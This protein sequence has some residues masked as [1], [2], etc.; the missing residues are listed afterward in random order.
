MVTSANSLTLL[1]ILGIPIFLILLESS[2]PRWIPALAFSLL[3][4][5]DL[6]DGRLAR[7][8]GI[9]TTGAVLDLLADK[10]LVCSALIFSIGNG[11]DAW[12]ALVII[13][14]EFIVTAAR[15]LAPSIIHANKLA[16]WKTFVQMMAVVG[17]I[18]SIPYSW[19]GMLAATALTIVS[20]LQYLWIARKNIQL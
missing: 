18:L 5:T 8:N 3:A 13:A 11:V 9:S 4:L 14:R 2:F 16:K 6:F 15:A 12:M 20:G 19:W 10:L 17:V 7:K 1:R